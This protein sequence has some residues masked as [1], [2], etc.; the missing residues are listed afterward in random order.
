MAS[1][2]ARELLRESLMVLPILMVFHTKVASLSVVDGSS[3]KP[4]LNPDLDDRHNRGR[5]ANEQRKPYR[6]WILLDKLAPVYDEI[7]RGDVVTCASPDYPDV[8]LVKRVVGVAGDVVQT[9]AFKQAYVRVPR[10]HLWI[11]GDNANVSQDSNSFGPISR[12]LVS[13]RVVAVVWPPW[14]VGFVR[15]QDPSTVGTVPHSVVMLGDED[16][17]HGVGNANDV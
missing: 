8:T 1:S 10:G 13:A 12:G 7:R 16:L 9:R 2:F 6:D 15:S 5:P 4:T 17:E 14:R 3:M 11:E